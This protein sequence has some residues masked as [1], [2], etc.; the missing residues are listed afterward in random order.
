M[1]KRLFYK[2]LSQKTGYVDKIT[3]SN[4]FKLIELYNNI[5]RLNLLIVSLFRRRTW[6]LLGD[7]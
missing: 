1:H 3:N 2:L 6:L 4:K 5:F 7:Q